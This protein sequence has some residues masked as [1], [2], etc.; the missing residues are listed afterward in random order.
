MKKFVNERINGAALSAKLLAQIKSVEDQFFSG[1]MTAEQ[2]RQALGS[3][4]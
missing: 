3:L 2:A 1:T 4:K